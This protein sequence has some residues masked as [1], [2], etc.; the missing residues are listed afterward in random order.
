MHVLYIPDGNRRYAK[1]N[2]LSLE[3][4]YVEGGRSISKV[5]KSLIKEKV[6]EISIFILAEHNLKR[7]LEEILA[8]A[9]GARKVIENY[10]IS[11]KEL[12]KIKY[13]VL[14]TIDSEVKLPFLELVKL[15]E[16]NSAKKVNFLV[17][18]SGEHAE[19]QINPV[20]V[21]IRAG[22]IIRLSDTFPIHKNTAFYSTGKLNPEVTEKEIS[23]IFENYREYGKPT[24]T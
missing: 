2:K 11:D 15:T 3:E 23:K 20:D 24:L 7:N 8:I 17:G 22:Q 4:A 5:I 10:F 1:Q 18:Y 16:N 12:M 13:E 14:S 6:N 19:K 21:A 9:K